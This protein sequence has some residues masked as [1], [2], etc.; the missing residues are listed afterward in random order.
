MDFSKAT[1]SITS[2]RGFVFPGRAN[3]AEAIFPHDVTFER[4]HFLRS[5]R[6]TRAKFQGNATFSSANFRGRVQLDRMRFS[7]DAIFYNARFQRFAYMPHNQFDS[8]ANFGWSRFE[9]QS[10]LTHSHFKGESVFDRATFDDAGFYGIDAKHHLVRFWRAEFGKVP[11][12]RASHFVVPPNM[13]G[14]RVHYASYTRGP[15]WHQLF[16]RAQDEKDASKFRRLKELAQDAK[17]HERELDFFA[18]ELK[19]KRFYETREFW[20]IFLS[21]AYE[22]LSDFGRSIER[23]VFWLLL[24]ITAS[25]SIILSASSPAYLTA[26]GGILA[27]VPALIFFRCIEQGPIWLSYLILIPAALALLAM[28]P[29]ALV[30]S[31]SLSVPFVGP[32][33]WADDCSPIKALRGT[34]QLEVLPIVAVAAHTALS[35]LLLFFIGLGLRNRFRIGK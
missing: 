3:F 14:M 15:L 11:D 32:S 13:E 17:H 1:L 29:A 2:F 9:S 8:F 22:K 26:A 10:V 31:L 23:P 30:L 27:F 4:A 19:A 21:V 25:G 28:S 20:R 12:F 24:L 18:N 34:C 33:G 7:K 16:G 6:F 5:A 35:V